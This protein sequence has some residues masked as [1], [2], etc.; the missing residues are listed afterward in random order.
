MELSGKT[1]LVGLIGYPVSHSVSPPMHNAAFAKIGLDWRYVPL[2]VPT[3]PSTRIGEAVCGV[4]ALGMKGA[5]VTVPHKQAVMPHLDSLTQAARAIGAVNTISVG[6]DGTLNGD[7]TDAPG[8]V[9]DLLDHGVTL[10][11]KRVLLL[12]AGGSA[13]AVAYGLAEAGCATVTLLNRTQARAKQIA[14]DMTPFFAN[15]LFASGSMPDD[16]AKIAVQSDIIVNSTSLGMSPHVDGLPW[17]ESVAFRT[18]QVV[19]DLIYSPAETRLLA[20][21]KADGAQ[22]I[23]GLGMLVWQGAIAFELWTG[24]PAPIDVMRDAS[25]R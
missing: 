3:E 4:R 20:K 6:D 8:F 14:A 7:N 24:Q 9:R 2:P 13:R 12:G 21:A 1:H 5:N 11:G 18:D 25:G 15:C 22:T 19:Y 17:N 10:N 23:N 16:I